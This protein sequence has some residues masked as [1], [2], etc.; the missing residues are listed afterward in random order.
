VGKVLL[1]TSW[2]MN[3]TRPEAFTYITQLKESLGLLKPFTIFVLPP[4]TLLWQVKELLQ[5]TSILI[6]AQNMHWER[7]GPYTGEISPLM[8]E[9]IGVDI[10][11]IGH[12][13]RRDYFGETDLI[14][15]KKVLSAL[16]HGLIPLICVGEKQVERE[17]G[18]SQE[19][20]H[21]QLVAALQ[22]VHLPHTDGVWIAYEPVWAIGE[23][24]IP[25]EPSYASDIQSE[26]RQILVDQFGEETGEKIP[27]LYG[28]S[29][30]VENAVAFLR[31]PNIDGLF[32]GRA[33]WEVG[34]FLE[35]IRQVRQAF[36]ESE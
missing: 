11:E 35:I 20:V 3:K 17:H 32:L 19:V 31:E 29:V 22:D 2:K 6:G 5:G 18:R 21:R 30:N 1:G 14:V 26:I 13:E 8:L 10:V 36:S 4:F 7:S 15:N 25:A 9:D 33:G 34:S 24:G 28:G 16:K 23:G 12:S 27:I